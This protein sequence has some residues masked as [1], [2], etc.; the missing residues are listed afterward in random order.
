[1]SEATFADLRREVGGG[2]RRARR[3][4]YQALNLREQLALQ[5]AE[6]DALWRHSARER[7]AA[8]R[9]GELSAY[10]LGIWAANAPAE[11]PLVNGELPWITAKLV[12]VVEAGE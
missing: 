8:F 11:V 2:T 9:A 12:D 5:E 1:M 10:Q 4:D 7:L 6:R 3:T